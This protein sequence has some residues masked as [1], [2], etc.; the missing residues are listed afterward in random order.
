MSRTHL[1]SADHVSDSSVS[2]ALGKWTPE[3]DRVLL[4]GIRRGFSDAQGAE[5]LEGRTKCAVKDRREAFMIYRGVKPWRQHMRRVAH[6]C[7]EVLRLGANFA[8]ISLEAW[9]R[10]HGLAH[11]ELPLE[12]A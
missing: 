3:E 1:C 9:R 7:D 11:A 8:G 12:T 5:M 10:E 6:F 4:W 2:D